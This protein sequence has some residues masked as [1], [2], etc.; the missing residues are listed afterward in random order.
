MTD[1]E[2]SLE[3][4]ETW[5]KHYFYAT[6]TEI[7]YWIYFTDTLTSAFVTGFF[8]GR[9]GFFFKSYHNQP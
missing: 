3:A 5:Q 2:R 7:S 9:A 6:R 1:L 4:R 8:V